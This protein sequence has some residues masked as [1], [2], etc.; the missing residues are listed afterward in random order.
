MSLADVCSAGFLVFIL[1][2]DQ[3]WDGIYIAATDNQI[4]SV[5]LL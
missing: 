2:I 3:R 5:P 1:D 4:K